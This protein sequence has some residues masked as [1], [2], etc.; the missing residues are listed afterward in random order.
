[1][2]KKDIFVEKVQ[3]IFGPKHA[4]IMKHLY[5]KPPTTFRINTNKTSTSDALLQLKN[6]GFKIKP[7]PLKNSYIVEDRPDN[8][9]LSET[10]LFNHGKI[11]IQRLSSMVPVNMLAPKEGEKI[12]DLCAAPGSKTSQIALVT[13]CK[14]QIVAVDNNKNRV[15]KMEDNLKRQG[16][17]KVQIINENGIGLQR[18]YKLFNNYFDRVLLDA[19][20]SNEGLICLTDHE[21]FDYWHPKLPKKLSKLQ[22][23]LMASAIRMLRPGG[24]LVYSTCTFSKEE[25]EDIVAWTVKRFKNMSLLEVKKI[26]PDGE[27]TGFFAAKLVKLE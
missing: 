1:M 10:E 9:K 8:K 11:Y 18:K 13:N 15:Y 24:T 25:N 2:E 23:K 19:P 17:E 16:F 7:G 27:F 20:C 22:K 6:E 14:S 21:A 26:L 4:R 5:S 12:L 3:K